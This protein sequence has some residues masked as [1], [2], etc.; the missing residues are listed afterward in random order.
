[1][2]RVAFWLVIVAALLGL[3]D[4]TDAVV[5][6]FTD[7]TTFLTATGAT[8]ATGPLPDLGFVGT[9]PV[10]V[11]NV[12]F[13]ITSPARTSSSEWGEIRLSTGPR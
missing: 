13:T 12:T 5:V 6:T 4:L 7:E 10:T 3:A 2:I 11:G 1:M 9:G 8:A